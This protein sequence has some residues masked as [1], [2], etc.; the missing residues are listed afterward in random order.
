MSN[1][2]YKSILKLQK[3]KLAAVKK[4]YLEKRK[5]EYENGIKLTGIKFRKAIHILPLLAIKLMRKLEKQELHIIGD[6]REKQK[7][8]VIY[9][10]THIGGDD[11]QIA[12][13]AIKKHAYLFLGDPEDLYQRI[14]GALLEINGVISME[15]RPQ[16]S[17]INELLDLGLLSEAEIEEFKQLINQDRKIAKERAIELLKNKGNLL[18]FPEG[19]WNLSPNLPVMKLFSGTVKM[20]LE[21]GAEIVPIAIE[22]YEKRFY[23]NIGENIKVT[24]RGATSVQYYNELLR[25]AMATLKWQIWEYQ[26]LKKREDCPTEE[27][28]INEIMGRSDYVYKVEDVYETMYHDKTITNPEDVKGLFLRHTR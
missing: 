14:E 18:I 17:F 10:C 11:I 26:G 27:E 7:P 2:E 23:V 8:P 20:A 22:Q 25:D 12:F 5:Y 6:K 28:F 15:T 24:D 19:A 4:Y 21:T 16:E 13:E 9:A 3:M 1:F